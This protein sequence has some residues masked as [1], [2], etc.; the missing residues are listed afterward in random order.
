[1]GDVIRDTLLISDVE[2]RKDK[3]GVRRPCP[4]LRMLAFDCSKF[5]LT[6]SAFNSINKNMNDSIGSGTRKEG[7][8][9]STHI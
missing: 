9:S 4:I 8:A 7:V 1:M 2:L 3:D 6:R 5:S